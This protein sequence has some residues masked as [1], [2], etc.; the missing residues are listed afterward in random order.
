MITPGRTLLLISLIKHF[1][2]HAIMIFSIYVKEW[3][4]SLSTSNFMLLTVGVMVIHTYKVLRHSAGSNCLYVC[5]ISRN[6]YMHA[7]DLVPL[8]S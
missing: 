6:S 2:L 5:L 3:M 8:A 4:D 1:S 7:H